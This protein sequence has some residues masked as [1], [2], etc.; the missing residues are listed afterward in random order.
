[1]YLG[2]CMTRVR[3]LGWGTDPLAFL[4][5]IPSQAQAGLVC[6]DREDL[7]SL[8]SLGQKASCKVT[9]KKPVLFQK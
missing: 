2:E 4:D 3:G 9:P 1:M 5:T 6:S 7:S 8:W